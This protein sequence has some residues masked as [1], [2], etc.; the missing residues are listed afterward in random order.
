MYLNNFGEKPVSITLQ[1]FVS[2]TCL[3]Q[4]LF[5]QHF[6]RLNAVGVRSQESMSTARSMITI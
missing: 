2:F 5:I 1:T 6:R 3:D 4:D